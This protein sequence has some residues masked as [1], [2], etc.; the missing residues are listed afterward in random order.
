MQILTGLLSKWTHQLPTPFCFWNNGFIVCGI[1]QVVFFSQPGLFGLLVMRHLKLPY[2]SLRKMN[3]AITGFVVSGLR[4][5]WTT[6]NYIAELPRALPSAKAPHLCRRSQIAPEFLF[7][8]PVAGEVLLVLSHWLY[9]T[10]PV[11][12]STARNS[13]ARSD[14]EHTRR[15]Q[16]S[17]TWPNRIIN[18]NWIRVPL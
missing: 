10:S 5:F 6:S 3:S 1:L 17:I 9:L 7:L 8:K 11:H 2:W 4:H 14:L 13:P 18:L 12:I 16:K 15:H